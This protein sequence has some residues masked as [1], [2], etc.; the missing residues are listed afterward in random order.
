MIFSITYTGRSTPDLGYLLHKNPYRPQTFELSYGKA[1]VFYPEVSDERTT[2]SLLLDI[3]PVDL[4]RGKTGG[5]GGLFDYVNDRPYVSSSFMSAAIAKV[6][7]TAMTGRADARRTLSDSPLNLTASVAMLPCRGE[8]DMLNRVFEPLGYDVRYE[9]FAS[10]EC[11]AG[12][13]ESDFVNLTLRG[14]VRLRDLLRH[15]YVL[16]PVFDRQKHY[17]VGE[18]EVEKLMRNA[19]DWLPDHPEKT[20]ITGRYLKRRR[21][22]INMAFER[23]AAANIADGESPLPEEASPEEKPEPELKL[24]AR[25]L[26]AVI[27]A[28]KAHGVKSVIDIGCGDGKLLKL[29]LGEGRFSRMAGADVSV[30]ALARASERIGLEHAGERLS[31]RVKLF[32]SS[33]TYRDSRFSGYDAACVIE[34]IEHMDPPRLSA[35][36][37]VLFEHAKPPLVILT[38][39]NREYNARYG[40][41]SP[42]GLRHSDHRFEWTRDEFRSWA[43]GAAGRFGY[44]VSFSDI[45]EAD[46]TCGAP[47]QMGVFAIC[48]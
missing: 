11:F 41:L 10:D 45:G 47:T 20:Y 3:N 1:Y 39:P 15:V 46:K 19:E 13:G 34:V 21:S 30:A 12:W 29:L 24:N 33:V 44:N 6:F 40:F 23:L 5:T 28:L 43:A 48:E 22:L 32:Q 25:R 36:E 37:R 27:D 2:A 38:T 4:A 16:I 9:I 14:N 8:R 18:D 7:G 31:E 26:D 42:D 35:F 17:W